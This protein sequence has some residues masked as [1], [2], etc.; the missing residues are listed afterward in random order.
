MDASGCLSLYRR[1]HLDHHVLQLTHP[2]L[3]VQVSKKELF[4]LGRAIVADSELVPSLDVQLSFVFSPSELVTPT[5]IPLL[6]E[7]AGL[8]AH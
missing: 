1:I 8:C 7:S 2:A 3:A 5:D 6:S 4:C